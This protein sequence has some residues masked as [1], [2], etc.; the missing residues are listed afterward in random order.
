VL[1][2]GS[3]WVTGRRDVTL[4]WEAPNL[5]S[6][7]W[8]IVSVDGN[9]P[10]AAERPAELAFGPGAFALWDG[11]RHS[12][13]VAIA[14]ERQLFTHGSGVVTL[15]NCPAEP[16]RARMASV[17]GATPRIALSAD[18]NIALVAETATLRLQRLSAAPFGSG[19]ETRLRSG[20][21]FEVATAGGP[22]RL[23]LAPRGQFSVALPCGSFAG[24]WRSDASPAGPYARFSPEAPPAG[25]GESATRIVNFFTGDVL[26]AIGPN[27][28]IALFVNRGDSLAGKPVR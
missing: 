9:A 15:A 7:R 17:I 21:A 14:F 2:D 27:R 11:C 19:V 28:D 20:Q 5:L 16:L 12:E 23:T 3:H 25:C 24:R 22:A 1:A 6:G 26:V 18:G 8:R 13:G 4:G 10:P